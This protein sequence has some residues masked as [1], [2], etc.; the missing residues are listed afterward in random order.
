[1]TIN[2]H[3]NQISVLILSHLK[4]LWAVRDS[5]FWDVGAK[6]KILFPLKRA[7]S[8]LFWKVAVLC[9]SPSLPACKQT[10]SDLSQ[11]LITT[12]RKI[13]NAKTWQSWP[14][15]GPLALCPSC[16]LLPVLSWDLLSSLFYYYPVISLYFQWYDFS[17]PF[18]SLF[19]YLVFV[20]ISFG[21]VQ[22][23]LIVFQYGPSEDGR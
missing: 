2:S 16:L 21:K 11:V 3:W 12:S 23:H 15:A 10:F 8:N 4:S 17:C 9:S 6:G 13:P 14:G 1:M 20:Q 5:N 18:L 22:S 7:N 19:M